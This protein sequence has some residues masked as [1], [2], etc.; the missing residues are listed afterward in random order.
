LPVYMKMSNSHGLIMTTP[1]L[2]T[3]GLIIY[4]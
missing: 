2:K 4:W 3:N 1:L